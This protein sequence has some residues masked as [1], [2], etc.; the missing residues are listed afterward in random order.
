MKRPESMWLHEPPDAAAHLAQ[1][2]A[3]VE[4]GL[5]GVDVAGVKLHAIHAL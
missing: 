2:E 4:Q 1:E 3:A 5:G